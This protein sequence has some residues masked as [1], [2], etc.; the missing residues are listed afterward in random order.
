MATSNTAVA[1]NPNSIPAGQSTPRR[2]FAEF[3]SGLVI[4]KSVDGTVLYEDPASN[5]I[6]VF[7]APAIVPELPWKTNPQVGHLLGGV[8]DAAGQLVDSAEVT[9]A[10]TD[11][12]DPGPVAGRTSLSTHTD[13]SGAYGGVDLA[14]GSYQVTVTPLGQAPHTAPDTVQVTPGQV[15]R[16]DIKVDRDSPTVTVRAQ[17]SWP[18]LAPVTLAGT[19]EDPG[20]GIASVVLRVLDSHGELRLSLEP[21]DGQGAPSISWTRT[22]LLETPSQPSLAGQTY[23]LEATATDRAGNTHTTGVTITVAH[24]PP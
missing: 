13:G 8:T 15:A 5:P 6:P 4:G 11:S 2:P 14:P 23:T 21:I 19:V 7:A 1:G 20:S 9:I 12:D 16:L 3:A 24:Q 10:T 18:L 17:P 22:I